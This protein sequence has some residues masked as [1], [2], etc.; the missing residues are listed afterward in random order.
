[1]DLLVQI[2]IR[3]E[4]RR[5]TVIANLAKELSKRDIRFEPGLSFERRSLDGS[6]RWERVG[7]LRPRI[8]A[9]TISRRFRMIT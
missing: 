9:E 2:G 4:V 7:E 5:V 1:V 3:D 6:P 8:L